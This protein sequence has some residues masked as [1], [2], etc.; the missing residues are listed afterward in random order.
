MT[1]KKTHF[2]YV[3]F[4]YVTRVPLDETLLMIECLEWY[5]IFF[6]FFGRYT[7]STYHSYSTILRGFIWSESVRYSEI[8]SK[9]ILEK[10]GGFRY[11]ITD[12]F[13]DFLS[14]CLSFSIVM[15]SN[16]QPDFFSARLGHLLGYETSSCEFHT[17]CIS[18]SC[19]V[20]FFS[21]PCP[22]FFS[23]PP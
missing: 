11:Y 14:A 2:L 5:I 3:P 23:L 16:K 4:S 13:F 21:H 12:D 17:F 18:P 22:R 1:K 9:A 8:Y 7:H 15:V 20:S 6:F 19:A 10:L